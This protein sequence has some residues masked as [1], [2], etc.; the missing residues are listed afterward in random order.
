MI[1]TNDMPKTYKSYANGYKALIDTTF[2]KGKDYRNGVFYMDSTEN[3]EDRIVEVGGL[4]D[5][6]TWNAGDRA[7]QSTLKEGYSKVFTQ[8]RYGHETPIGYMA[9]KF[10]ARD[11]TLT[12]RLSVQLGKKAY[13]LQQKAAFSLLSYGF[14]DTNTYLSA[15]NGSTVS[16]LGPDGK[17]LFSTLHPCSPENSTTWSNALADNGAVSEA[18]LEAMIINLDQQLDDRGEKKHYGE[19]GYIWLVPVDKF[20]EASRI[21]GSEKRSGTADNDMNVYKGGYDGSEI[22]VRKVPWL[23]DVSPTAHFLIAKEVVEE[24]MPLVVLS[25]EDFNTDDYTDDA[26]RTAYVRG[27]MIFSVGFVSGRGI[28]GSEGSGAGTYSA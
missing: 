20:A 1:G 4:G 13:L 6:S 16:A 17:R 2:K 25:S 10:Q 26:T 14:S 21:V 8:I 12:K 18:T 9:Q 5:F 28:C 3:F 22:E 24:E 15:T 23:K 11:M 27:Q 7:S 19:E